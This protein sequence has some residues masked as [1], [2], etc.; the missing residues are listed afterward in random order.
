MGVTDTGADVGGKMVIATVGNGLAARVGVRVTGTG[1]GKVGVAAGVRDGT[2][3]ITGAGPVS[4]AV[5]SK[6]MISESKIER[7]IDPP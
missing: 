1:T 7:C 2:N 3:V 6:I 5:T 4:H